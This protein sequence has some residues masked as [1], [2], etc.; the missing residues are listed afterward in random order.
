[1][2]AVKAKEEIL[3]I[4]KRVEADC[5]DKSPSGVS[6]SVNVASERIRQIL[7]EHDILP[8]GSLDLLRFMCNTWSVID[9]WAYSHVAMSR[10]DAMAHYP[11]I[12]GTGNQ[13]RL[14]RLGQ[15]PYDLEKLH[16]VVPKLLE[17]THE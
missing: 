1:M 7:N 5:Y 4:L 12:Q 8:S 14:H 9:A 10:E 17:E 15:Q 16:A 13:I 3:S 6:L 2:S 11:V